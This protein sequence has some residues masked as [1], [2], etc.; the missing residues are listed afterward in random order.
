MGARTLEQA[1]SQAQSIARAAMTGNSRHKKIYQ[2]RAAL[3]AEA[4]YRRYQIGPTKWR[5]KHV[6]WF[7]KDFCEQK[8]YAPATMYDYWRACE[9]VLYGL[10][11]YGN[12][13]PHL[14]GP[15]QTR[16]GDM[17]SGSTRGRKPKL[18]KRL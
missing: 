17:P 5:V 12:F 10:E 11:R 6:L 1:K 18:K 4:I 15:W 13:S 7:F 9:A 8:Q 16:T 2:G 3:M 14:I